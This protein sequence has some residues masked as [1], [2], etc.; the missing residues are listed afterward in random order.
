MNLCCPLFSHIRL[1]EKS[2]VSGFGAKSFVG[3]K[4][5][6]RQRLPL[7]VQNIF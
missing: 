7:P 4:A 5:I 6:A 1:F 3:L 2:R